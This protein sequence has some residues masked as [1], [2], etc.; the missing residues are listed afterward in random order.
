[1]IGQYDWSRITGW[2]QAREGKIWTDTAGMMEGLVFS[3]RLVRGMQEAKMKGFVA[4]PLVID[5][6]D[7][8]VLRDTPMPKY[9]LVEVTGR[10]DFDRQLFD[11]HEGLLCPTCETWRPKPKGKY[12]FEDKMMLP[13]LNTW[14]GSDLVKFGKIA[15]NL[16]YC[17]PRFIELVKANGW[18]GFEFHTFFPGL[19]RVVKT[20]SPNWLAE[21]E[22]VAKEKYPQYF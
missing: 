13:L 15:M 5:K 14:D 6:I 1:M 19:P 11:E 20:D 9:Y 17:T 4:H 3:E 12:G 8:P 7:S 2:A 16:Y 22:A 10:V 21:F 18:I